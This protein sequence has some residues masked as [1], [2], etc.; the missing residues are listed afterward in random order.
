MKILKRIRYWLRGWKSE[1]VARERLVC[2]YC[3]GQPEIMP[4]QK[5]VLRCRDCGRQTHI[6]HFITM[7]QERLDRGAQ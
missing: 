5:D 7:V 2:P 1:E 3:H 6:Q 4:G